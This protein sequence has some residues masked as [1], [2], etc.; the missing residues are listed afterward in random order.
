[1]TY[2]RCP[3]RGC[4]YVTRSLQG[5][6]LH[7]RKIHAEWCFVCSKRFRGCG[8]LTRHALNYTNRDPEDREHLALYALAIARRHVRGRRRY[9]QLYLQ[10]LDALEELT[11][12][13]RAEDV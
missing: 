1:M 6:R 5:L 2:Y 10:G 11:E 9:E 8:A 13:R 4:G 7:Y 12:V 3:A